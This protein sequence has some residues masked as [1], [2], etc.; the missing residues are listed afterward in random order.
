MK[1]DQHE[2]LLFL[3]ISLTA[4]VLINCGL[5]RFQSVL[6]PYV[7]IVF[8][9]G[10]LLSVLA[11]STGSSA[12]FFDSLH[13]WANI[14]P[15]LLLFSFLP[16][17]LFG[18]AIDLNIRHV[19]STFSSAI[20]LALPGSLIFSFLLAAL[21]KI[22]LPASYQ[23][24][25]NLCFTVGSILCATD[26]VSVLALL[27]DVG[28]SPRLKV[29]MTLEA[30][31]NDSVALVLYT[32]YFNALKKE[33]KDF[34]LIGVENITLFTLKVLFFS[35]LIGIAIG[36]FTCLCISWTNR[37]LNHEDAIMQIILTISCAFLS[38][39]IA[40]EVLKVSGIIACIFAG[41]VIASLGKPIILEH[42]I[43]T[44]VWET[45]AWVANTLIFMIAGLLI[46]NTSYSI[47]LEDVGIILLV[48]EFVQL[49]RGA[50]VYAFYPLLSYWGYGISY[51]E[52]IFV[53][54]S[55]VRGAIGITL[56]LA[57][58]K[59][60][61]LEDPN[62]DR[63]FIIVGGVIALTLIVNGSFAKPMLLYLGLAKRSTEET[64]IL[65]SYSRKRIS[66]RVKDSL[67]SLQHRNTFYDE[68]LLS[69][70]SENDQEVSGNSKSNDQSQVLTPFSTLAANSY[71]TISWG[72]TNML[73]SNRTKINQNLLCRLRQTYLDIVRAA[74]SNQIN[75]GILPRNS[76]V[77]MTLLYSV[78]VGTEF[79]HRW[80]SKDWDVLRPSLTPV[81]SYSWIYSVIQPIA[82]SL[83]IM[84]QR[85][86]HS[87]VVCLLTNYITAHKYAQ[88]TAPHYL[89]NTEYTDTL[90]LA[91]IIK[92]SED[93]VADALEVY[94]ALNKDLLEQHVL[95]QVQRMV[96]HVQDD[97]IQ[98]LKDE[99]IV[100]Q[101]EAEA[102]VA[103]IE[104]QND[105]VWADDSSH[106]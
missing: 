103:E 8:I 95:E 96:Q 20:L 69:K 54:W 65:Q 9:F 90:E 49:L 62:G 2:V 102:L 50:M 47:K 44:N 7:V 39:Y 24:S 60:G 27:K 85:R 83:C 88:K 4:G 19:Q 6:L 53:A 61:A 18:D 43:M 51:K 68:N 15:D 17:L 82:P 1:V 99:G 86:W 98:Q 94:H 32:L 104:N 42:E 81:P 25:W 11:C 105:L 13:Q 63:V 73:M 75:E 101:T 28:T 77:T 26:P 14:D 87:F 100:Y 74:Y 84:L 64:A 3:F 92:E 55:G 30:L 37:R 40:Q 46:G 22:S 80:G 48:Y 78:D 12:P 93:S 57:V 89:E 56:A 76:I 45:M 67:R 16:A 41:L 72:S 5:S 33:K 91:C 70:F 36:L 97:T 38:F 58:S 106:T 29:L 34:T 23:W 66:R 52:G 31:F 79:A 59:S 21:L 35:P 71:I 10:I